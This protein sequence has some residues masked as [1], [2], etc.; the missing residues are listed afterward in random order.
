MNALTIRLPQPE[1]A[2]IKTVVKKKILRKLSDGK[3]Q[4][5]LMIDLNIVLDKAV[6]VRA[7]QLTFG[8]FEDAVVAGLAGK[9]QCDYLYCDPK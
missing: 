3:A 2:F 5:K 8:D 6:F 1:L 7:R 4:M 9:F